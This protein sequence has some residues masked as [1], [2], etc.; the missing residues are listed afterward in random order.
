MKHLTEDHE[1]QV[2]HSKARPYNPPR[3]LVYGAVREITSGG[4]GKA[5]EGNMGGAKPRP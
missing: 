5:N 2:Q 3:L 4:S 1:Q